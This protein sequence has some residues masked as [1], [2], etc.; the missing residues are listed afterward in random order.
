MH[1]MYHILF[2]D[3][4]VGYMNCFHLFVIVNNTAMNIGVQIA[5]QVPAFN[6]LDIYPEMGL[7]DHM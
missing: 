7:L 2:I 3:I 4:S 1:C 5:V 6:S